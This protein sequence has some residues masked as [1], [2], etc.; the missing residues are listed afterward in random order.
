MR[1][2][3]KDMITVDL[4]SHYVFW[5]EDGRLGHVRMAMHTLAKFFSAGDT[6]ADEISKLIGVPAEVTHDGLWEN[7]STN[8]MIPHP[9]EGT[10]VARDSLV[11]EYSN[12]Y[13][14]DGARW[15]PTKY[16]NR[17]V[18]LTRREARLKKELAELQSSISSITSTDFSADKLRADK[19]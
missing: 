6:L 15:F 2:Y 16:A 1:V 8:G 17:L 3:V 19:R 5:T 13:D 14:Q 7:I 11:F 12:Y 9:F 10:V 4:A 18:K